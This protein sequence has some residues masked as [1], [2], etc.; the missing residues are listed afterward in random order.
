MKCSNCPQEIKGL[1]SIIH[2]EG[3]RAKNVC[4]KCFKKLKSRKRVKES[5]LDKYVKEQNEK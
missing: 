2:L 4:Q 1:P 3:K 5:W